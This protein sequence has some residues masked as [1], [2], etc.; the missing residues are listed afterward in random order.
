MGDYY[1]GLYPSQQQLNVDMD[2]HEE[3]YLHMS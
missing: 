2:Q 1:C 3:L